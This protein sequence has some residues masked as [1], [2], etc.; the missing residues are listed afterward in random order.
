MKVKDVQSLCDLSKQVGCSGTRYSVFLS[1]P[2]CQP[3]TKTK[4]QESLWQWQDQP[5]GAKSNDEE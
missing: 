4:K 5:F 3:T 2:H 1:L